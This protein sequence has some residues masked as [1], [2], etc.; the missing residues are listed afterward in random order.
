MGCLAVSL[1]EPKL[2]TKY[3]SDLTICE[4]ISIDS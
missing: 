3:L 4:Q 2:Q 1:E